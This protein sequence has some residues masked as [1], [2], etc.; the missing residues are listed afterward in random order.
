MWLYRASL[1][2]YATSHLPAK[3]IFSF[4]AV[5]NDRLLF[6]SRL[7]IETSEKKYKLCDLRL[8]VTTR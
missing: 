4:V 7:V 5:G 3:K 8:G 2:V 6:A 1:K